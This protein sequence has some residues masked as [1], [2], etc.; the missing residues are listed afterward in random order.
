[1]SN[2]S[3]PLDST[4][5]SVRPHPNGWSHSDKSMSSVIGVKRSK[6]RALSDTI[7]HH[8]NPTAILKSVFVQN[9]GWAMQVYTIYT[10]LAIRL[11]CN[12]FFPGSVDI[13]FVVFATQITIIII[14][15][16]TIMWK[17]FGG[18]KF[19]AIWRLTQSLMGRTKNYALTATDGYW[20]GVCQLWRW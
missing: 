4:H 1:M 19:A 2:Q 11:S 8:P 13:L 20:R 5:K 15:I 3:T 14:T 16:F 10:T 7:G 18:I 17:L 9:I 6:P 12:C